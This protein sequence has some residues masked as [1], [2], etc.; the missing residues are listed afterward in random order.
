[1]NCYA[2]ANLANLGSFGY[3]WSNLQGACYS[4]TTVFSGPYCQ[5]I[6][7]CMAANF[8]PQSNVQTF[9]FTD[10]ST[11]ASWTPTLKC[12]KN[13]YFY[14]Y[15]ALSTAYSSIVQFTYPT[16]PS[17]MMLSVYYSPPNNETTTFV[18]D[19]LGNLQG[20]SISGGSTL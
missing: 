2:C 14:M 4:N 6:E 7:D 3:R 9:T 15:T 8:T 20:F 17:G 13:Y 5:T 16:L 1:M 19:T 12:S 10:N 18:S 11:F